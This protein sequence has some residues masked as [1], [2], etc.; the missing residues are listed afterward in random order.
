MKNCRRWLV[1]V[2]I[3]LAVLTGSV[4]AQSEE[5]PEEDWGNEYDTEVVRGKVLDV[6]EFEP[7]EDDWFFTGRQVVTV[8]ITEGRFQG[9]IQDIENMFTGIPYRD[10]ELKK[11]NQVL[12]LLELDE[13]LLHNV[14][15][16]DVARDSYLY[17]AL[18]VFVFAVVLVARLKGVKALVTLAIMGFVI[19]RWLLPLILKGYNPLLLTVLFSSLIT[20][21]TLTIVSGLNKKTAAAIIG[22]IGG[23]L[24]AGLFAWIFGEA[25]RLTGFSE[26]AQMLHFADLAVDLDMR[27]L[28]FAGIIIG[29]LGAVMD[30]AMSIS[31]AITELKVA[32][33]RL[34]FKGLFKAGYNIGKDALGTMVNTLILAYTGGALPLLLLFMT[35]NMGYM[36]IIN[37]D[38]IATEVIRSLAGSFGMLAAVPLTAAVASFFLTQFSG[39]SGS[40][41]KLFFPRARED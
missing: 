23:V 40:L 35:T 14:N 29:A 5:V 9:H 7:V 17:I 10:L 2:L 26:E 16:Y 38:M 22:T 36:R 31:S 24:A 27:G 11:G 30:V 25:A 6:S 32:N 33:P 18:V 37:M 28:L 12:L 19:F 15:L 20:L 41:K 39:P 34:A 21:A 1:L 3:G 4:Y 13:G 8:E